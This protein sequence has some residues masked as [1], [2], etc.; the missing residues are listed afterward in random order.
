MNDMFWVPKGPLR[1]PRALLCGWPKLDFSCDGSSPAADDEG[2]L[3]SDGTYTTVA[4]HRVADRGKLI[5]HKHMRGG[6]LNTM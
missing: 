5:V 2:L 6:S 4:R 1:V 3:L